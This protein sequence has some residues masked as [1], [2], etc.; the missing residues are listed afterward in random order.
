[1]ERT[2]ASFKTLRLYP[3]LHHVVGHYLIFAS[4]P[5]RN[6]VRQNSA[7]RLEVDTQTIRLQEEQRFDRL[8]VTSDY[9]GLIQRYPIRESGALNRITRELAFPSR[10]HYESA[11]RKLL[12][13]D[14]GALTFLRSLF[15]DLN[16]VLN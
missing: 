16:G 1:M 9:E 3:Q 4:L 12:Q 2:A 5:S 11:V 8:V 6:E 15:A 10:S 7:I 14:D 13:D